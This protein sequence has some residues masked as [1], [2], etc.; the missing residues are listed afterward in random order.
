MNHN[1][2]VSILISSFNR[3][4]DLQENI[5][6]IQ[7]IY[8]KNY[9][10]IVVDGGSTDGTAEFLKNINI[11]NFKIHILDKDYG[12]AYTHT[13]GMKQ[14]RGEIIICLDDDCFLSKNVVSETVRIF[15]KYENLGSI[16]FGLI[17]PNTNY[18]EELY[19]SKK[20]INDEKYNITNSYEIKNYASSQA[21][22]KKALEE[23]NYMDLN[24]SWGTNTE[25]LDLNY[26][27]IAHGYNTIKIDE[28]ISFHT[29]SP[30]NRNVDSYIINRVNGMLWIILKHFPLNVLVKYYVK[31]I[32]LCFYYA[33]INYNLNYILGFIKSLKK[34]KYFLNNSKRVPNEI[35]KK[36]LPPLGWYFSLPKKTKWFGE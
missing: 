28:L 1:P 15:Q 2:L 36:V 33:I 30:T 34:T 25:D 32:C 5:N 31:F 7:E 8:Y 13:F 24:W 3:L 9:E 4:N 12:S 11:K 27:I 22:R 18:S 10:V 6:R 29:V 35:I 20:I 21:F 26:S 14:A 19:I 17:N 23:V 16:G